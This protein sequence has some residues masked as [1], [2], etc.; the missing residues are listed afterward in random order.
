MN[1]GADVDCASFCPILTMADTSDS[2]T[3][4]A[5]DLPSPGASVAF[6]PGERAVIHFRSGA[7]TLDNT[8]F[9]TQSHAHRVPDHGHQCHC[10]ERILHC[11]ADFS[12][13]ALR[14]H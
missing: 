1:A 10:C 3:L 9:L 13:H 6:L 7:T 4:L 8:F 12:A 14:S 2:F 5:E 11:G